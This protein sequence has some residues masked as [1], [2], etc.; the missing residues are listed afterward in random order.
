MEPD[1]NKPWVFFH[2]DLDGI[3]SYLLICWLYGEQLPYTAVSNAQKLSTDYRAWAENFGKHIKR[4][5]FV[6]LDV[7]S[8]AE[9]I[10][11]SSNFIF[12]HH[13][14][15]AL[16]FKNAHFIN[17]S[18]AGSCSRLIYNNLKP[19]LNLTDAQKTLVLLADDF[20]SGKQQI[21]LSYKLNVVFHNTQNK[22]NSFI[23]NYYKGIQ[24]FDKFQLATIKFYER[25]RDAYIARLKTF[26][27]ILPVA[28]KD[29]KI[30]AVFCDQYID[31]VL[32]HVLQTTKADIVFGVIS[33]TQRVCIRIP[34]DSDLDCVALA[35]K[36][37]DGG[38]HRFAAGG[39]ITPTFLEITKKLV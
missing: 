4:T 27:G 18:S 7:S 12:D 13:D 16:K 37:A 20:D 21:P 36:I 10:D 25:D 28:G 19:K 5:F 34:E 23:D 15:A 30:C 9:D 38:G 6:D 17:D 33:A 31:E 8:I 1:N 2:R 14:T 22:V 39:V 11:F 3:I 26:K 35:R 24:P 32:R 29:R